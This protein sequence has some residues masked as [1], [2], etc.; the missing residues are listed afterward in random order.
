MLIQ[1]SAKIQ[2]ASLESRIFVGSKF[3]QD[4]DTTQ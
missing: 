4:H 1:I 3:H 2:S